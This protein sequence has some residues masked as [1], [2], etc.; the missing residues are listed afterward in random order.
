MPTSRVPNAFAG[1]GAV[2]QNGG[3]LPVYRCGECYGEVVWATSARTGRKY[4]AN[5]FSG[6]HRQR[7]YIGASLHGKVCAKRKSEVL[8]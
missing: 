6:Y 5:V 8:D 4:L 1:Q 2:R 3:T 7:Y